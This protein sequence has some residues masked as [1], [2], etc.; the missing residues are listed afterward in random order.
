MAKYLSRAKRLD[1]AV[2]PLGEA[3]NT[4]QM[5]LDVM[6][7]QEVPRWELLSNASNI[8]EGAKD[9]VECLKEELENWLDNLPENLQSSMKAD[10]LQEAIDALDTLV[11]DIDETTSN[12]NDL[13]T[14]F[15][16]S[17]KG[18]KPMD[19]EEAKET[20]QSVIDKLDEMSCPDVMFPGMY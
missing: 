10:S 8:I 5:I 17:A 14:E 15:E 16:E 12:L 20:L 4:V 13:V 18:N 6:E 3:Q 19:L 11:E 9:E 7:E 1:N 2:A